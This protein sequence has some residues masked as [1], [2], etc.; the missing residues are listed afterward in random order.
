MRAVTVISLFF[1]AAGCRREAPTF[2]RDV[3][4]ILFAR[5]APC[6][7]AGG[8]A[9][10][11]LTTYEDAARRATQIARVTTRRI[12]PPW[13]A[14]P[15]VAY[16]NERR[17]GDGEVATLARWAEARAPVG[18]RA[19]IPPAPLFADGWLLGKPD[20]V[21]ELP[22]YA[23]AA[24]GADDYRNFVV[25]APVAATRWV[26]AWE[27]HAN[28]RAIHHAIVNVDRNG[29][30]RARDGADGKPGYAG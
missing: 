10:F 2:S 25:R 22:A 27:F 14:R 18:D 19:A 4:P 30:A 5:C 21:V 24:G 12:M 13:K 15:G 11:A 6:H 26:A 17:L 9:P 3:A 1:A 20:V 8:A 23:L 29:F 28:G 16:A 7:R